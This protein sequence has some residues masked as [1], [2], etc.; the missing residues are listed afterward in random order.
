MNRG[1][2][3]ALPRHSVWRRDG[4]GGIAGM[5]PSVQLMSF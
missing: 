5:S 4:I 3:V 2:Q 1:V